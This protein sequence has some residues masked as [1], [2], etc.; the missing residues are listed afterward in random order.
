MNHSPTVVTEAKPERYL[1]FNLGSESYG[2]PVLHVREIIRLCQITPV[3]NMPPHVRGVINLRGTV[4]PVLD[5]RAKFSMAPAEYGDRACIIVMQ[6]GSSSGR[7]TLIGVIVDAVE[8]VVQL[9][10][11]QIEPCPDFGGSASTR[12]IR[13]VATIQ[14]GVKTLLETEKI[15]QEEGTITLTAADIMPPDARQ[16]RGGQPTLEN[17]NH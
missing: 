17:Q 7:P 2:L 16:R 3:P 1:T 5:L 6:L 14:G 13:G 8:E 9:A 11:S 10:A 12:Y 15:F 4:I